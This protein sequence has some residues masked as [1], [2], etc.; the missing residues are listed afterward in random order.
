[1]IYLKKQNRDGE[2]N[3]KDIKIRSQ[4]EFWKKDFGD[5]Y[6]SRNNSKALI[7][8]NMNFF[9]NI[10]KKTYNI[11]SFI[12]FGS[13]IGLNLIAIN[14]LIPQSKITGIDIN[15]KSLNILKK[16]LPECKILEKS[17]SNKINLKADFVFTKG[18]LIHVN[19]LLLDK[20]YQNLYRCSKN[21]ILIAEY[22]NP[23][24]VKL[25]YRGN[26]EKLFKRDFCYEIMNKYSDLKL[27]DYGFV[28][29]FDNNFPQ[30]D[31][32]WFLLKK[33]N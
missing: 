32:N 27:I 19:P 26:N 23:S 7:S 4:E 30:D 12:E 20:V 15:K 9:S 1:M 6:I 14:N 5:R 22:Y 16:T 11:Q 10:L 24:P 33:N 13:N 17:I 8:S 29:R 3:L 21:Y 31:L 2:K 18:V 28:Y 25:D